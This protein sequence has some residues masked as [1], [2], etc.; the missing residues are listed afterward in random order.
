M[1]I[2]T[3]TITAVYIRHSDIQM[4]RT[5]GINKIMIYLEPYVIKKA[6]QIKK[7][8]IDMMEQ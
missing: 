6:N 8:K 5:E 1:S 3:A 2:Q 4:N 7:K